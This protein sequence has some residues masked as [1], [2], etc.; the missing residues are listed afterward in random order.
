MI[1]AMPKLLW[2]PPA[3]LVERLREELP[4]LPGARIRRLERELDFDTALGL[5]TSGRDRLYAAVAGDRRA[6]ANVVMN[7]LAGTG[8][9]P[10]AVDGEE[11]GKLI[12][13]RARIPRAAFVEAL[14][15]SATA[16][17]SAEKYLADGVVA[18][19]SELE[20]LVE[21]V[22]A[23]NEKEVA[24]YRAGKQG[25]LG[26][27]VGQVMRETQGKADARVVNELLREK[28]GA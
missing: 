23:A 1:G 4:E 16:G 14:A 26:F 3:E 8:V 28:L 12:E 10:N 13:A 21:R 19:L 18:D 27:F 20:P 7:E 15:A 17:F 25:L 6:V 9:D 24:A 11:L 5:V 22:L 2:E